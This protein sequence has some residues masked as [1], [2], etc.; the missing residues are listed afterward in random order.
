MRNG[1]MGPTGRGLIISFDDGFESI[2]TRA[3]PILRKNNLRA[4]FFIVSSF[5]G[6]RDYLSW[7]QLLEMKAAGMNIESHTHT[8]PVLTK[9]SREKIKEELTTSKE[10]L[11]GK[12]QSEITALCVPGGFTN[13]IVAEIAR[14]CGYTALCTSLI[15]LNRIDKAHFELRRLGIKGFDSMSR[16]ADLAHGRILPIYEYRLRQAALSTLKRILGVENYE[17][18]KT[19]LL[20]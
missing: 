13:G 16:F 19:F 20:R 5:V 10:M 1:F 15:G 9:L 2:Y 14:E 12:L 18:I 17:K 11:E 7:D 6:T 8:H 3:M 4:T